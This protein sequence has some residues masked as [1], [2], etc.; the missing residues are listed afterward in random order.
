M[1]DGPISIAYDFLQP[2]ENISTEFLQRAYSR[3]TRKTVITTKR[4]REP[5]GGI[6]WGEGGSGGGRHVCGTV[7]VLAEIVDGLSA[8]EG[9]RE[10]MPS[11]S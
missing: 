7:A 3:R 2:R 4:L 6:G 8:L 1:I 9:G 11:R 10:G 5:G